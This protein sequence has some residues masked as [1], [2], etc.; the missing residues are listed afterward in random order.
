VLIAGRILEERRDDDL[1][2]IN[3]WQ[4]FRESVNN[5]VLTM[6]DCFN[7]YR[8]INRMY[9]VH[10][11]YT[12]LHKANIIKE[13]FEL[14]EEIITS[15][16]VFTKKGRS[17]LSKA[18]RKLAESNGA[19]VSIYTCGIYI[20]V[21]GC[22]SRR[23]FIVDTHQ[24]SPELGGSGTGLLKVFS[25]KDRRSQRD[26]S[27]WVWKRLAQSGVKSNTMQSFLIIEE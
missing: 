15:S 2:V 9:D 11:A 24:I 7:R 23:L 14:F 25:G 21:I 12:I 26:V 5:L 6:P 3:E 1:P 27:T 10:E 22:R 8:D 18:L 17:S 20:F 13:L 16:K 19:K 4:F